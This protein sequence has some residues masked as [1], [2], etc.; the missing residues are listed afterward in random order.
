MAIFAI[1]VFLW[2]TVLAKKDVATVAMLYAGG[3]VSNH[4]DFH[5]AA[6]KARHSLIGIEIVVNP[7]VNKENNAVDITTYNKLLHIY[8]IQIRRAF[9]PITVIYV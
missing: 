1:V 9:Q 5:F 3:C 2:G 6:Y 4:A 7:V 8:K